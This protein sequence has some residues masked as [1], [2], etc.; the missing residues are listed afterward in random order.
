MKN[1]KSTIVGLATVLV[2]VAIII[3]V[4]SGKKTDTAKSTDSSRSAATSET[5][6]SANPD[7]TATS[8]VTISNFAFSPANITVKAGTTVTW[9]N[10]DDVGHTVTADSASSD[11][12][13][14]KSFTK[15]ETYSYTFKKAG[16]YTY[17]CQPHPYMHGTVVVTE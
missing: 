3:F 1:Q 16:T 15:G 4:V 12:P 6:K 5:A 13:D 8:S 10:N 2:V 11:A 14:S 9:T 7:A 17:H